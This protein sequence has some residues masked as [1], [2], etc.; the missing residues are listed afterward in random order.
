M[1]N[2]TRVLND[3]GNASNNGYYR[4]FRI[5]T[6][7]TRSR[8]A[9]STNIH[10]PSPKSFIPLI[11]QSFGNAFR[12]VQERHGVPFK[13][14]PVLVYIITARSITGVSCF[15]LKTPECLRLEENSNSG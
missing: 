3:N 2:V 14:L 15:S 7:R 5:T 1:L 10:T 6:T 8:Y 11:P 12:F 13:S 9:F 4:T